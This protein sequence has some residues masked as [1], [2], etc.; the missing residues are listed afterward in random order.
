MHVGSGNEGPKTIA[1]YFHQLWKKCHGLKSTRY[2]HLISSL[3]CNDENLIQFT[4]N[5][6]YLGAYISDTPK[7]DIIMKVWSVLRAMKHFCK[8][9]DIDLR[10]KA[11]IYI[12]GPMNAL[13]WELNHGIYRNITF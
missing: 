8:G 11:H 7:E 4:H 5:F 3:T 12:G 10:T 6:K 9:K 1:M 2:Y 13:L